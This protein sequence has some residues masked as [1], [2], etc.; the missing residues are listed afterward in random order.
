MLVAEKKRYSYSDILYEQERENKRINKKLE[1][2]KKKRAKIKKRLATFRVI[3]YSV[4]SLIMVGIIILL[5]MRYSHINKI[6]YSIQLL[7]KRISQQEDEYQLKKVSLEEYTQTN[8]IEKKAIEE[9]GMSYPKPDQRVYLGIAYDVRDVVNVDDN[10]VESDS[11]NS[12]IRRL[13]K[14]LLTKID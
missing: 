3:T 1:E 13:L 8:L 9:L 6:Q 7:E 11:K 4:L 10:E 12:I 14:K 2:Q 5:L